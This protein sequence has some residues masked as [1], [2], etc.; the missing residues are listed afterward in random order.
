M[1][2]RLR[3]YL[4][5]HRWQRVRAEDGSFYRKCRDCGKDSF[6]PEGQV[7]LEWGSPFG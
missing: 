5:Y 3:C 1:A 2:K 6:P 4:G 7:P